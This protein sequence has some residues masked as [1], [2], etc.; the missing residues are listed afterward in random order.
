MNKYY[1]EFINYFEKE[2]KSACV[3]F[4]LDKLEKNEIGIVELYNEILAP[5]LNNI[6]C[7]LDNKEL[8]IWKEH[9][10]SGI[11]RTIIECC[12]PYVAKVSDKSGNGLVIVTC[13]SEEYHELGARMVA[14]FFTISGFD[15]VFIGSNTP[16]E[17]I[18]DVIRIVQPKYLVLSVTN[19][20]HIVSAKKT[21]DSIRNKGNSDVK[22]LVGGNAF[23][24]NA[25]IYK[26]IGADAILKSFEDIKALGRKEAEL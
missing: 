6:T 2:D 25:Q 9:V 5:A 22:I 19:Y 21:I 7:S 13:P 4:A 23:V 3:N 18:I 20:Y 1:N 26:E 10:R 11:V 12:Y 24:K 17:E 15:V 14:D 16:K 8:C